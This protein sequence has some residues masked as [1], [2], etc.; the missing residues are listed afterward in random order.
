M[1]ARRSEDGEYRVGWAQALKVT[2][3]TKAVAADTGETLYP[4]RR[5]TALIGGLG[6]LAMSSTVAVNGYLWLFV[7]DRRHGWAVLGI[8]TLLVVSLFIALV[9]ITRNVVTF[10]PARNGGD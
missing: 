10:R 5:A 7:L 6:A 2:N 3:F 8:T 4:D 9:L 1:E